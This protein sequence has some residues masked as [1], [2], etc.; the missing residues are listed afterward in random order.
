MG[1]IGTDQ[2]ALDFTITVGCKTVTGCDTSTKICEGFRIRACVFSVVLE[3]VV[4]SCSYL[5]G[6][7]SGIVRRRPPTTSK[8]RSRFRTPSPVFDRLASRRLNQASAQAETRKEPT[9][10]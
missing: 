9:L 10:S 8:R 1:T 2:T 5:D 3:M 6:D 4:R 7:L